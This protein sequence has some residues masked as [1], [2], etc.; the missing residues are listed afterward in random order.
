MRAK[1]HNFSLKKKIFFFFSFMNFEKQLFF[2]SDNYY[3]FRTRQNTVVFFFLSIL[4]NI[5]TTGIHFGL[6]QFETYK[7]VNELIFWLTWQVSGIVVRC[8]IEINIFRYFN[9]CGRRCRWFWSKIQKTHRN[10]NHFEILKNKLKLY[11][12]LNCS[13]IDEFT[14]SISEKSVF[15]L[16]LFRSFVRSFRFSRFYFSVCS[17]FTRFSF[18]IPLLSLSSPL[19]HKTVIPILCSSFVVMCGVYE[20]KTGP[21]TRLEE[22]RF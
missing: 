6:L 13:H 22:K 21:L 3:Y 17:F 11:F 18:Q 15:F 20:E 16:F 10:T 1:K 4:F 14:R 2:D 19:F 5:E 7:L 9:W 12:S 8:T